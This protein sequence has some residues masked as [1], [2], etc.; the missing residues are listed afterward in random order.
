MSFAAIDSALTE[1]F[2]ASGVLP[3]SSVATE[4]EAFTPPAKA[5]PWARLTNLP[6]QPSA[7]TLGDGGTDLHL[8]IFQIDL[9][10]PQGEGKG[11]SLKMAGRIAEHFKA[12]AGF[13][14]E[15]Q[16]VRSTSCGRSEGRVD[17]GW[18]R[19]TLSVN[20]KAHVER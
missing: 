20:W 4:N 11:R 7:A 3:Q 13:T 19:I 16:H 12:G 18:F 17:S 1:R 10:F 6:A 2:L 14:Y 9:Y 15:R 5:K 8:G